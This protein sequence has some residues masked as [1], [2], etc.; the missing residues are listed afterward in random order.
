M[1]PFDPRLLKYAKSARKYIVFLV[2][3]G[4]LMT[5]LIAVQT[6]LIAGALTPIFYGNGSLA[7]TAQLIVWLGAVF[8]LRSAFAFLQDALG[9]RAALRVISDLR[10]KVLRHAGD[11]GARWLSAGNT[12]R[13]ATLA[14]R[15]LDDLEAYFVSFLPQLLLSVTAAPA[16]IVVILYLDWISALAIVLCIPL[17]P[18]F[19]I[20]IGKMTA[21]YSSQRLQSMQRLGTQ[22]LDLLAGIT[23]LKA[24]GREQGPQKRV[25]ALGEAF[26][27]KTMQTLY[28]AFLSGA[29]LE[30]LA[31]LSTAIVAVE[32]GFRMVAGNLLLFEGLVIIMLTPE[33]F[34]PLRE[35][36]TQFHASANGVAAANQAFE[37][38]ETPLDFAAPLDSAQLASLGNTSKQATQEN[39]SNADGSRAD[40]IAL[41]G[42]AESATGF[43]SIPDLKASPIRFE[44]VSVYAH[45]RATVA[46]AH[47]TAQIAPGKVTVLQGVSGAGKSTTVQL[48]MQLLQPSE[49]KIFV[50]ETPLNLIRREDWWR[51]ITWVPQRPVLVPGTVAENLG[52]ANP[53][54]DERVLSAAQLAGF[55]EVVAS[56]P[57]GWETQIG[58]GG[59]GL[60]V[61]Q[62][63]RLSL[64]RA[65]LQETPIVVLD[66]PSAHLDAVAEEFVTAAIT[67]LRERD[68]TV[69]IV[70]HRAAITKLADNVISV[71]S[72]TRDISA[73]I[74]LRNQRRFDQEE[75]ARRELAKLDY[76]LPTSWGRKQKDT[77]I[78]T[79][80]GDRND[81]SAS[82]A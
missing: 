75:H 66:E 64:T 25:R 51:Q 47:L 80:G 4:I 17:I 48:L 60:S 33:V 39:I 79:D 12:A 9:H 2:L 19:M 46:P 73:E 52:V 77:S 34:K 23:T 35:V 26:A 8:L 28:V 5:L 45:E 32:V 56:L 53:E 71:H 59:V 54:Q 67:A 10:R 15:G 6:L 50:G 44:N 22:L 1:R 69:V 40:D 36:G 41:D 70:A 11:L 20:L 31:T 13:T 76:A 42:T 38:I 24:V 16:L 72:G 62:R 43:T 14:T 3:L 57:Q 65:L 37:I 18:L 29:A 55:A 61:G 58:Q 7:D 49:G 74:A 21:N 27:Q 63:Q 82:N 78:E 68:C 81:R 30:F